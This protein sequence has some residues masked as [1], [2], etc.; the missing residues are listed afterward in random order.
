[1]LALA[2][3]IGGSHATCA[4]VHDRNLVA[5]RTIHVDKP[6]FRH[7]LPSLEK[8]VRD[9]I[10]HAGIPANNCAGLVLGFPGIV[11]S[12][13]G[14]VISTNAKFNDAVEFDMQRWAKE[15]F[16]LRFVVENDCRLALLGEH[17]TGAAMDAQDV[18]LVTL[19]TGI[20]AAAM[21]AG[22][23]LRGKYDQA[24]C[25]GG[26]LPVVL[27][28][29]TCTCGNVGCAE[30]EVSTWALPQICRDWPGFSGSELA[31]AQAIDFACL[32]ACGDRGD[33]VATEVLA[34]CYQIWGALAV[35]LIHAYSPEVLLFGGGVL[36]RE[37][38]ILPP[39]RAH[40]H[41]HAWSPRDVVQI[42]T[43][44]LGPSAAL[45]GAVP[46]LREV[47]V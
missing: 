25:L 3:E 35:A 33:Q 29:R 44:A 6:N 38:D 32:F 46:L 1:M 11:D 21:I 22:Q 37:R 15:Q 34:R 28:G 19:G 31:S 43:A 26:H 23:P 9:V 39:I 45:Y 4:L 20:G 16:G 5:Q 36:A 2:L 17:F 18:V 30:A 10:G 41:R 7:M 42:K 40:V 14:R 8:L 13:S 47:L 12:R 27:A 24:G